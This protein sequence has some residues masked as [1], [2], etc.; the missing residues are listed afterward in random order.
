MISSKEIKQLD[1]TVT[2]NGYNTK[3]VDSVLSECALT[4]DAY[5]KENEELYRKMEL[6]AAKIE[7][8]RLEENAIKTALVTAEKMAEKIKKESNDEATEL[9]EKSRQEADST[10][11]S[12]KTE[13]D[14]IISS[15]REYS[16]TLIEDKTNEA[17]E[18]ITNAQNKANEAINSAKIVAQDILDQAKQISED[19]ISK[20]KAEKEAYEIL[21]NTIKNDAKEFIE[22]VKALYN[23]ELEALNSANLETSDEDTKQAQKDVD[24]IDDDVSS[25]KEEIEDVSSSIPD[26]VVIE[27][28]QDEKIE[29]EQEVE[30]AEAS[31]ESQDDFEIIDDEPELEEPEPMTFEPEIEQKEVEEAEETQSEELNEPAIIELDDEDEEDDE[32]TDPMAAVEAFSKT[33]VTPVS[34]DART[35]TEITDEADMQSQSSLFDDETSLPFESYF[36]VKREDAHTDKSQVISLV[37]PEDDEED[38]EPRFRGFFKKKK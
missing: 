4:I 8:Y 3:E 5:Q 21:T 34:A 7:E 14:K 37:P 24:D 16:S 26:E 2:Q 18:I 27:S 32:L 6:L 25:L 31:Q 38:D 36:N 19:L 33:S 12:A 20:S 30:E 10:V 22:K 23:A 1:L 28:T 11:S 9:L 29:V 15:A 13:A 17:S 35:V